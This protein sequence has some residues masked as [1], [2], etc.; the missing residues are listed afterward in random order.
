VL[1]A[2]RPLKAAIRKGEATEV[3]EEE[4]RAEAL[5]RRAAAIEDD[6]VGKKSIN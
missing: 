4:R 1:Y 2:R 5:S 6:G 3:A